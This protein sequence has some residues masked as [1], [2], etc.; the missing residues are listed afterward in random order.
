MQPKSLLEDRHQD[1]RIHSRTPIVSIHVDEILVADGLLDLV[2][3][4]PAYNIC[5]QEWLN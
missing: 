1:H 3:H 2:A 4:Q 5:W